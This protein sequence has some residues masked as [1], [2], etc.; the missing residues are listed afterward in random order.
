MPVLKIVVDGTLESSGPAFDPTTALH[1][2]SAVS[3]IGM[4][5][6][7]V[8][9]K[10]TVI[11]RATLPDGRDVWIETTLTLFVTAADALRAHYRH[12]L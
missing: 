7:T 10:P 4:P 2:T 11:L 9:G 1:V 3:V 8:S 6:G 12:A 5:E